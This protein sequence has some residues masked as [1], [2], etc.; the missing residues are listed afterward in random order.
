M[1]QTHQCHTNYWDRLS[2]LR[3]YSLERRRE[4][5][6]ILYMY[7]FV[8]GLIRIQFFEIFL[9]RG[10]KVRRK[11]KQAAP[12]NV[13]KM[14]QNSFF[15]RGAQLYNLLPEELRVH[16]GIDA[17]N[18]KHVDSFKKKLDLFLM[19][20]PDQPD[21]PELVRAAETCVPGC[22]VTV[23]ELGGVR[24]WRCQ[25]RPFLREKEACGNYCK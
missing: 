10:L 2:D 8:I 6:I 16:E 23:S 17:P 5:L 24:A 9:E 7:R 13:K 12:A 22:R 25:S 19:T 15:Y 4:R 20:I 11:F 3:I 18:R 1:T 21:I 14:R